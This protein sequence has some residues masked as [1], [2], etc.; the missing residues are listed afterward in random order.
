MKIVEYLSFLAEI[1][2]A[3]GAIRNIEKW[4]KRFELWEKRTGKIEELSK[5]NQQKVQLI[6]ALLHDP[7]FIILDEPQSGLDPVNMVL[8]RELLQELRAEGRTILLSTHMMAE[9]ERMAD[10]I[11]L[12]HSGKIVLSGTLEEVRNS[13][14]RNTLH[15]DF[16]GDGSFLSTLDDVRDASI[17]TNSAELSLKEGGDPQ[18]V[19]ASSIGRLRI[20]RFELAAPSL[21]AIFIDKVG[22]DT[23]ENAR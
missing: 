19:L 2:N 15:M 17:Q 20:R 10:D 22:A 1:K 13:F 16:E 12:V 6:G 11:I 5:G 21:E 18:K 23:L 4:M 14:G 3:K 9:A 8:V 7:E